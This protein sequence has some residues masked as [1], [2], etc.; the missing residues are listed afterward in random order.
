MLEHFTETDLVLRKA[1][2]LLQTGG[3]FAFSTPN[4]RG[5]SASKNMREFLRNSPA[6]HFTILSPRGLARLLARYGLVLR[7]VRVTGHHPERFPGVLGRGTPLELLPAPVL[8]AASRLL[9]LGDTFEAYAVKG[10][11]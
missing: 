11:L 10:D 1:A 9:G 7:R 2:S 3:V 4:G 6:D 8:H 5:V